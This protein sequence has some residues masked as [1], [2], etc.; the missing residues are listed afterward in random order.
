VSIV[1]TTTAETEFEKFLGA[2]DEGA[3][4]RAVSEL[5]PS[6]HEVDR[7]ATRIW[8][9]FYPLALADALDSAEDP[10]ALAQKLLLQGRYRLRDQIDRSHR[11]F[12]GHR[13]W[14]EVKRV[15]AEHADTSPDPAARLSDEILVAARRAAELAKTE[16]SLLVG[17][18][19][20]AFMTVR[21]AGLAAFNSSPGEVDT[22][23]KALRREPE[24]VLRERA[25]DDA[26]GLLGFLRTTD[27]QW[28]VVWDESDPAARFKM[29]HRQEVASAS[30]RD[31][32]DWSQIDPRCTVGE[33]PIPVQCRSASCGTCWVGVLGGAEKLSPVEERERR[34]V[35]QLGYADTDEPQPLIRLSCQAQGLGAVSIVIPPWNGVFGK[36]LGGQ[37]RQGDGGAAQAQAASAAEQS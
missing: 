28:T 35:R 25:R 13:F 9:A 14:P 32:R 10:D 37:K 17:V 18:T 1:T 34:V 3:W 29:M 2:Q 15:V 8:F 31:T 4:E 6:I 27:K 7:N 11:F 5:L 19:A 12:Y 22:D 23:R 21:Q 26:Q 16:E 33:G 36:Y 24:D 20:A 30:P